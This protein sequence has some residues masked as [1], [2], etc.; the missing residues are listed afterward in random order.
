MVTAWWESDISISSSAKEYV[1]AAWSV[2][3]LG[4]LL[5]FGAFWLIQQQLDA[6]R[7]LEFKWVAENRHRALNKDIVNELNTVESIRDLFQVSE[8]VTQED[9]G[10]LARTLLE[11]HQGLQ[12]LGWLPRIPNAQWPAF[13]SN[14]GNASRGKP[15]I[16][17]HPQGGKGPAV[18]RDAHFPVLFIEPQQGN[19]TLFGFDCSSSPLYLD[20]LERARDT[21]D[22]VVS[23]RIGLE[24]DGRFGFAAFLPV[25]DN[26]ITRGQTTA[27][28]HLRGYALGI[29]RISELAK[30]ATSAL[31][32]RGVEFL[33]LD[34]SA[35]EAERYLDFYPSRL[36]LPSLSSAEDWQAW[37]RKT[38]PRLTQALQVAD[39]EWSVT[40][41][42]T[43]EFRSA[44]GFQQGHWVVLAS[45][46][47]VTVLVTLYLLRIVQSL[48]V[49]T[50]MEGELR[51]REALFRQMTEAIQEVFWIQ[52]P[53]SRRVLYVSPA[54]EKIWGRSC[55]DLYREPGS[56]LDNIHPDDRSNVEASLRRIPD[57]ELEQVFRVLR[58]D[59]ATRWVRSR[60][61]N[62]C[63]E[64]GQVYRIAGIREDITE[65]KQ[66]EDALRK[67]EKQLRS[68]FTQ[69]PDIIK[70]VD[71]TG[72]IL[73]MSRPLPDLPVDEAIGQDSTD[74]LPPEYRQRYNKGLGK[75][76]RTGRIDHFQYATASSTWWD[77]RI[78][79]IRQE[80]GVCEAMIIDSDITETKNLEAKAMRSARLASLGVLAAGVAHEIGRAHV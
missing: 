39:R 76:F 16:E 12:A 77:V 63:N 78:V 11:G 71:E 60:T 49:R 57:E 75:A 5:S 80:D 43:A 69:S 56:F 54:Y 18:Q 44:G 13:E 50:M 3:V 24:Q 2:A 7:L 36:S 45:G 15:I 4:A 59:G 29:F 21:G 32:P 14:A 33:I 48:G 9:F 40:F 10:A 22:M 41:A 35:P 51:E 47:A 46:L 52:T 73:S 79:P 31:E 72:T 1:I 64:T 6:H 34:E 67:S 62:V 23:G 61:F 26:G 28:G 19:E 70:I 65:I 55:D 38:G 37:Q 68:L 8:Q 20:L 25:Y 27:R 58:P 42:P 66:V 30:V 17:A 53:D 74:L